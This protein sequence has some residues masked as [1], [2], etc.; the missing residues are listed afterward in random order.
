MAT[1]KNCPDCQAA[2]GELHKDGCDVNQMAMN[3]EED[4][5]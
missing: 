5:I 1:A 2:P 3:Y 4:E